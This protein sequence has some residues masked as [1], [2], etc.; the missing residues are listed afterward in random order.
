M[1]ENTTNDA[2]LATPMT[3]DAVETLTTEANPETTQEVA[4]ATPEDA[5]VDTEAQEEL[6][7]EVKV[8]SQGEKIL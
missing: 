1:E 4:E 7:E 8:G 5:P 2:E 3:A 6:A